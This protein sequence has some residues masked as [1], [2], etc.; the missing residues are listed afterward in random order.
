MHWFTGTHAKRWH[1]MHGTTGS[2]PL[3]KD[4]F[5][6]VAIDSD[7]QFFAVCRYVER[8]PLAAGLVARA[9]DWRWSSLWRHCN[10]CHDGILHQ[11]PFAKP[12]N[13]LAIVNDSP[14]DSCLQGIGPLTVVGVGPTAP[15]IHDSF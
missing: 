3:Y 1:A 6:D 14:S 13:W 5:K 7:R 4:R 8:N 10:N 12:E 15:G 11:W 2:G 9:E